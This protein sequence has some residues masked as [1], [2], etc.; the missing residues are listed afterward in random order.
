MFIELTRY[1]YILD[2]YHPRAAHQ[3]EYGSLS[4]KLD[5]RLPFIDAVIAQAKSYVIHSEPDP[6][7]EPQMSMHITTLE[8]AVIE[9]TPPVPSFELPEDYHE[10]QMRLFEMLD[11]DPSFYFRDFLDEYGNQ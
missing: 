6:E 10:Q 9:E 8:P 4:K 3:D 11:A 1:Y 2:H 5:E 7:P